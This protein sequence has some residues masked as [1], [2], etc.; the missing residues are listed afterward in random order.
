MTAASAPARVASASLARVTP[1]IALSMVQSAADH[2]WDSASGAIGVRGRLAEASFELTD[3]GGRAVQVRFAGS[4]L[5]FRELL[6]RRDPEVWLVI[7]TDRDEEDLGVGVLSHL[8]GYRLRS[9]DPW[10]AVRQR[11]RAATIDARLVSGPQHREVALGLLETMP[12]DAWS[13]APA[14][15]LTRDHAFSAL[16]RSVLDLPAGATDLVAVLGWSAGPGLTEQWAD[17]RAR[18]GDALADGLSRWLSDSCG[19]GAPAVRA[20][21]VEGH[22]SELVPLGLLVD[23]LSSPEVS[24]TETVVATAHLAHRWGGP[25]PAVE[26]SLLSLAPQASLVVVSGL[27]DPRVHDQF[28]RTITQ[29]D[30]LAQQ[31]GASGPAARSTLLR[32]GLQQRLLLLS[33]ALR[34]Y[35]RHEADE[36]EAAYRSLQDHRLAIADARV[37]ALTAAVRVVRWLEDE[38][39][40]DRT[41]SYAGLAA[42]AVRQLESDGWL[43]AAVNDVASGSDEDEL[44]AGLAHVLE[45]ARIARDRHDQEFAAALVGATAA[46]TT[47]PGLAYG[48]SRVVPLERLLPDV[49]LPLVGRHVDRKE[50]VLLLVLDGMSTAASVDLLTD[51]LGSGEW[52]ELLLEGATQRSAGLS[53]L[54]SVTEISRASLLCG[55]L[56]QGQQEVERRGYQQLTATYGVPASLFHKRELDTVRSGFSLPDEVRSAIDDVHG[57]PLVTCVLNTIDDALDRS[58][59]AGTHWDVA[60]VKHLRALLDRARETSRTVVMTADH[61]HVV[62]R[63]QGRMR[64]QPDG[65]RKTRYRAAT[66]PVEP[67]EVLVEGP[68]VHTTDH[69]AVLAVDERLRYGPLKAGYHG[70]AA[71]AEVVVPVVVLVPTEQAGD[72]VLQVAPAQEPSWWSAPLSQAAIVPAV[73]APARPPAAAT[74]FDEP[75]LIAAESFGRQLVT[76]AVYTAQVRIAGR[77]ALT[78]EQVV[79]AVD[80]L[81]GGGGRLAGDQLALVLRLQPARLRGAVEQLG[82]LLNVDGYAVLTRD[83]ATGAVLLDETTAREQFGLPGDQRTG[84]R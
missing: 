40:A 77:L 53:L 52:Q 42:L 34:R 12:P 30:R 56:T 80:A 8:A 31:V 47:G 64:A 33:S 38:R 62:E 16:A 65:E 14:G 6:T 26:Q 2:R 72:P 3:P 41:P 70:G 63:R 27:A 21:L 5:A 45:L 75:E 9:P 79:G 60:Q 76:T 4:V 10:H 71:P 82:R 59:P 29:A 73:L 61:G 83:T 81:A 84:R 37:S 1:A 57:R 39:G 43:D 36:V 44:G 69:R 18:G 25:E 51:V 22:V 74:L 48:G 46:E 67:G 13:P 17:L 66:A 55:T 32:A 7:V 11:F 50:G 54:P 49:V 28:E 35:P 23:T 78:T 20:L 68:R 24:P 15:V 19:T 58:D